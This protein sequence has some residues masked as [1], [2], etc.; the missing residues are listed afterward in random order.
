MSVLHC[1]GGM[2]RNHNVVVKFRVDLARLLM[3]DEVTFFLLVSHR[4]SLWRKR[5][6]Q[7]D[8][9]RKIKVSVSCQPHPNGLLADLVRFLSA[10]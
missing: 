5:E 6:R 4:C 9:K 10:F 3:E 2:S 7:D 1:Y 8:L